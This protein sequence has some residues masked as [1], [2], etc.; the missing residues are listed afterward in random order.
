MADF[1]A[2]CVR[3]RATILVVGGTGT[4]KTTMINALSEFIPDTERVLTIEDSYE[5][6]LS[7]RHIISLQSR[8][9]SSADDTNIISQ[10]DLMVAALR[11]RPDRII[12]GEIREPPAAAVMLQAANTGHDGTMTPL[13]ASSPQVALNNRM[14]SLLVR[15]GSGFSDSVARSEVASA[16]DLVIQISRSGGTR[17]ISEIALVDPAYL[18][19]ESVRGLTVF[20]GVPANVGEPGILFRQ[21]GRVPRT[22][23][24]GMKLASTGD[25]DTRWMS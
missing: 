20:T 18:E 15:S 6:S 7:N 8:T 22:T 3:A 23:G 13:H 2:D 11:M 25:A 14:V 17:Y 5:L 9:R 10:E 12:V 24:L 21:V 4:G 1:L 16:I 19:P